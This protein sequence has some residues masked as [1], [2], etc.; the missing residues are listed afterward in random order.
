MET[1]L[2]R[3]APTFSVIRKFAF[4]RVRQ[5]TSFVISFPSLGLYMSQWQNQLTQHLRTA[6]A[7]SYYRYA[8]IYTHHALRSDFRFEI[9]HWLSYTYKLISSCIQGF[10]QAPQ[11]Q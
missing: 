7:A 5:R 4:S 10:I 11:T 3:M 1:I 9:F 8:V 2:A 6:A